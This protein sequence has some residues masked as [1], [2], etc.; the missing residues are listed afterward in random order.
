MDWPA[1]RLLVQVAAAALLLAGCW[2]PAGCAHYEARPISPERAAAELSDRSLNDDGL[3]KFLAANLGSEPLPWP[4]SQWNLD[5][6]VLAA[7]YYQPGLDVARAEWRVA[8]AGTMTAGE[9]PNPTLG[10]SGTYDST[11][12]PPWIPAVTFNIPIETAG[13]RGHRLA[14]A[15][16]LA[17]AARWNLLG[18]IWQAR[19]AVRTAL[20][21]L[22]SAREIETLL[23][24]QEAAQAEVVRLLE[25]QFAAGAVAGVEV[26]QVRIALDTTRLARQ[27]AHRQNAE[28]RAGLADALGLPAAALQDVSLSFAGLDE[29]PIAL[30]E[31]E[32]RRQALL[33]RADVRG[34]LDEYTASQSALQLEIA[35]QYP[36]LDLGPGYEYDQTDN[37][38]TLGVSLSLPILNQNRGPIAEARAKRELAAA[39]FFAVQGK[40][41]GQIDLALAGYQGALQQSATA[42]ALLGDLQKRRDSVRAMQQAGELDP[43]AVANA[44]VEYNT[45][46][47]S[48]LDAL[49]KAQEALGQLEDAVQS[50]QV[51]PPAM[52]QS[53]QINP[54][55]VQPAITHEP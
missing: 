53:A 46:A 29:F 4:L 38:W 55:P 10:L 9:R 16:H 23:A 7:C 15:Q 19:S 26:T 25:G 27:Q 28:A 42:G 40:A 8:T 30:T 1:W 17:D 37:K 24:R 45:G 6:L 12:P 44:E 32:V 3:R 36:D 13:K 2:L 47:L 18:A 11:T 35:K 52:L 21:S 33:N 49:V 14:E 51:M 5:Q 50:P 48:R 31:P 34:A 41:A 54:R 20:L 22:Y 43:M 39:R